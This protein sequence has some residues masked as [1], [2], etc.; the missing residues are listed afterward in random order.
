MT[1][2]AGRLLRAAGPPLAALLLTVCGCGPGDDQRKART[3]P[4]TAQGPLIHLYFPG[5]DDR[6]HAEARRLPGGLNTPV[7]RLHALGQLWL[8]GPQSDRLGRPLPQLESLR[9]DLSPAGRVYADLVPRPE[10]EPPRLGST[11]EAGAL[12]SLV[13]TLVLNVPEAREVVVLWNGVQPATLAGH[14]DTGAP[15]TPRLDLLA[16]D[17]TPPAPP[18]GR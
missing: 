14:L 12:Y 11:E 7:E 2:R 5:P 4:R 17:A 10:S 1:R 8:E 6:L 16:A 15:L 18:S 3:E 9:L 13:N